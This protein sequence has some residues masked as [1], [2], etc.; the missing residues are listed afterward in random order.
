MATVRL[1]EELGY[2]YLWLTDSSL[3]H[4]WNVFSYLTLAA[5]NSGP[6]LLIGPD[7]QSAHPA[8]PASSPSESRRSTRSPAAR[9]ILGIGVG[10]RPVE[11]LGW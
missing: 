4:A 6:E 3:L 8:T 2:D 11:A 10:D 7:R 5:V 9:A 1:I